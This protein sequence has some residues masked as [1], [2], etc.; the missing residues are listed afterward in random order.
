M[1]CH[2]ILALCQHH[3]LSEEFGFYNCRSDNGVLR[4]MSGLIA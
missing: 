4:K 1:D 2:V 3:N